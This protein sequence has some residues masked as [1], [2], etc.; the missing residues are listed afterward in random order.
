MSKNITRCYTALFLL[1]VILASCNQSPAG[2]HNEAILLR[3]A[4]LIDGNGGTPAHTDLLIQGDT[5]A[6]IGTQLDTTGV[7][8]IDLTGKT[9]MPALISAHTHIGTLKGTQTIPANYTRENIQAQL[10]KYAAYGV[11]NIQV[12]GTDR[13]ELFEN[14]LYDSLKNGSLPGARMLSAGYGFGVPGGAPPVSFAMDRVFRPIDT[15]Q[16]SRQ[17]DSLLQL[18]TDIVKIWVDDFKG[19]FKKMDPSI[20]HTIINEAHRNHLRVAAHAYYLSDARKLVADGIDIIGHSIRDSVIDDALVQ[21]MKNK[22]VSYIPT[23]SL[24]EFAYIYARKPEWLND[25]FFKR[26]LEP[27]VYEMITSEKYQQGLQKAPDYKQNIAAFETALKNLKKLFDAGILIALGTDSGA[28]PVRAQGFSEHLELELMVQ[29]GLTPLQA[30]TV[31]TKNA[32]TLLEINDRLG[33]LAKGKIADLIILD[34]NPAD[35]IRNTRNIEAVY[36]AG[37]Q[38]SK[39]PLVP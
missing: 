23:L 31:A 4:L 7:Q 20:Y 34:G 2:N 30:I 36:K 39:G 14:R 9:I 21:E 27:G 28:T 1:M 17:M 37:K 3:N 32:A 13:P 38:I 29:A 5:I 8:V 18:H 24:D 25:E 6:A 19:K 16:I 22:H 15:T 12:M 35:N 26:S 10:N 33:T 11:L